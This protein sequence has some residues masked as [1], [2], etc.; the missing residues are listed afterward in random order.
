MWKSDFTHPAKA[1]VSESRRKLQKIAREE[2]YLKAIESQTKLM[3]C[4][5]NNL[6]KAYS[7]LKDMRGTHNKNYNIP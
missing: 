1:T 6:T 3:N 5:S 4:Y 7:L 2:E